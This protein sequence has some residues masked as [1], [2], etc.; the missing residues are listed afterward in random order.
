VITIAE[1]DSGKIIGQ[2]PSNQG[3]VNAVDFSADGIH[4]A[5]AGDDGT[6]RIW[7]WRAAREVLRI[8]AHK[9]HVFHARFLP[10]GE[11]LISSADEPDIYH[12]DSATGQKLGAFLGHRH[13]VES[14][15]I[16]KDGTLVFSASADSTSRVWKVDGYQPLHTAHPGFKPRMLVSVVA[17]SDGTWFAAGDRFSLVSIWDVATADLQ[18]QVEQFDSVQ[19]VALSPDDRTLAVGDVAGVITLWQLPP[20]N[21]GAMPRLASA[22]GLSVL[23]RWRAHNGVIYSICFS[24]DGKLLSTGD[25]GRVIAWDIQADSQFGFHRTGD[26]TDLR[27]LGFLSDRTLLVSDS[28]N[29]LCRARLAGT[30]KSIELHATQMNAANGV[31]DAA[32]GRLAAKN[33]DL[34]IQVWDLG[35][36]NILYDWPMQRVGKGLDLAWISPG[37][38]LV[39]LNDDRRLRVC[40]VRDGMTEAEWKLQAGAIGNLTVSPNG[41]LIA[42][43]QDRSIRIWD[44]RSNHFQVIE[45]AHRPSV[46]DL[47]FS[48]DGKTL[49]STGND[50]QI[51]LWDV[52]SLR[53]LTSMSGHRGD[54]A[55]LVFEPH[56]RGLISIAEDQTL[57]FWSL[58]AGTELL[59]LT[60]LPGA[61]PVALSISQ[62]GLM[63]AC[64]MSNGCI[65]ALD[66]RSSESN[67]PPRSP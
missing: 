48:P 32:T 25:D 33:D 44:W 45:Q 31:I 21:G 15:D 27:L 1:V 6:V 60:P 22:N 56:G 4:L 52:A 16:S 35:T 28:E 67:P 46:T 58:S 36:G 37:H 8:D 43:S 57:R 9:T 10:S 53:K 11:S 18:T 65:V 61:T 24:P 55:Q 19:A 42:Y 12:W 51:S 29:R 26:A 47:K 39:L 7:D 50:R 41:N 30:S 59:E 20:E 14:I 5:S 23:R 63:L 13:S 62:D 34:G 54:I 64:E 38:H 17:N 2:F 66:V 3:E 49:A 40:D